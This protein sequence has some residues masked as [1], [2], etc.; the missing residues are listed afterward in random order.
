MIDASGWSTGTS[1]RSGGW[2]YKKGRQGGRAVPEGAGAD[3]DKP[4]GG[5]LAA[6]GQPAP[7]ARQPRRHLLGLPAEHRG[8]PGRASG[9]QHQVPAAE[10]KGLALIQRLQ[11]GAGRSEGQAGFCHDLVPVRHELGPGHD[12][13]LAQVIG[14]YAIRVDA[15]QAV[16]VPRR[17]AE[18]EAQG[19]PQGGLPVGGHG[20]RIPGQP[21]GQF[22][23][24]SPHRRR[25]AGLRGLLHRPGPGLVSACPGHRG[26]SVG[27][28]PAR[29]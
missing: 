24:G 12:R 2:P 10:E 8:F 3:A 1:S 17:M 7:G 18:R 29:C 27:T 26:T 20:R 19:F 22:H 25:A 5:S 23:R 9:G 13:Q 11:M 4:R 15:G 28:A 21:A 14:W 16:V 6:G